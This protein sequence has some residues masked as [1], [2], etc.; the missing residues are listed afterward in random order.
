MPQAIHAACTALAE[1]SHGNYAP[2]RTPGREP[3]MS[4]H[5][6][7]GACTHFSNSASAQRLVFF[8]RGQA[9]CDRRQQ[10]PWADREVYM[11]ARSVPHLDEA[12][13]AEVSQLS[14]IGGAMVKEEHVSDEQRKGLDRRHEE[15]PHSSLC[16]NLTDVTSRRGV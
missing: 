2:Q 4:D 5:M 16:R 8:C 12:Q 1:H 9:G 3:V 6:S 13:L 14:I 15:S 11:R 10:P 7:S